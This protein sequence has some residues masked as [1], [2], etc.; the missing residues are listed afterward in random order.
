[1]EIYQLQ[2]ALDN[3]A[4]QPQDIENK[5]DIDTKN[6]VNRKLRLYND[7]L[8]K[9][10]AHRHT[11]VVWMIIVVSVWLAFTAGIVI[12]QLIMYKLTDAVLCAL[13]TTTTVNVLGLAVIV[14]KGLFPKKKK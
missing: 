13:L 8:E 2:E 6:E 1:M 7:D 11:L 12:A 4:K 10:N 5:I 14:L 9:A 3:A